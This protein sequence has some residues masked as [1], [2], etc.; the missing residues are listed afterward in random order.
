MVEMSGSW[1][2]LGNGKQLSMFCLKKER[3]EKRDHCF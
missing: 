2:S 1:G 3:L